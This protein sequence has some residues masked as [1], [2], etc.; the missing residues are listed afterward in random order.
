MIRP[1]RSHAVVA[2]AAAAFLLALLTLWPAPVVTV[3]AGED[4]QAAVDAAPRGA[5][6]RLA[7]GIHEG[8]L[9][10]GRTISL[11]GE[12]GA[13]VV[14][15]LDADAAVHVTAPG[16]RIENV[17]VRGGWTGIDLDDAPGAVVR[18]V[19]VVGAD[20]QGVRVYKADALLEAV[21]VAGLED[22]HAQGIEVL[23][24][25][26][27]VVR[28]SAVTGGKVGIVGHLS[29]TLFEGN[30]VSETTLA[31][32]VIREMGSGTARSNKVTG[33][34][35]A[36]LYCGDMSFCE[37]EDNVVE[38]VSAAPGARSAAGWGLVVNYRAVASSSGD[39]LDGAAGEAVALSHSRITE[40]SPL[41]RGEPVGAAVWGAVSTVAGLAV[42][43][44]LYPLARRLWPRVERGGRYAAATGAGIA[45]LLVG[46][47]VQSFHMLEH[48]VQLSRVFADG[49]PS[50][51]ALVGSLVDTEW[52]HLVYNGAVLAGLG[53]VLYLR[54]QGWDPRGSN[55]LGDRLV[56]AV[57][58]LQGYHFVEH[59]VKVFQHVTTGAKVN[60]GILGHELN[61][62][63]LHFGLNAAVYLGFV[64]AT[65]AYLRGWGPRWAPGA[66]RRGQERPGLIA[67]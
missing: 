4:L 34:T 6:V 16:V 35:G 65:V 42:L 9:M 27:V 45:L 33:A 32:I 23:S 54:R 38:R 41:E 18:H 26:D 62:V 55:A 44:L 47:S 37:F 53:L 48:V 59:A 13:E 51:G 56:L 46:V 25:P 58:L 19:S 17:T 66:A 50:R 1:R 36:G 31:G 60:P 64:V 28:D 3:A 5:T 40:R 11:E 7:S 10:I 2:G 57:A 30:V 63:L 12:P 21:S 14:A 22:P 52:V 61:L 24:A 29:D 15:P 43:A 39:E 67:S 49:V 8:P 20:A